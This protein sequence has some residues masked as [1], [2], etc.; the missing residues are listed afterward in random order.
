MQKQFTIRDIARIANVDAS[1]VSRSLNDS[2][3]VAAD[4]KAR[5]RKIA[6]EGN[7]AF[8]AIARSLVT[9]R[10]GIIGLLVP[11]SFGEYQ[12]SLHLT[13]LINEIR[14]RLEVSDLDLITKFRSDAK[15]GNNIRHLV[16]SKR[17]DAL[18]I[19]NPDITPEELTFLH[20]R[21]VPAIFVHAIPN[22]ITL[23]QEEYIFADH[24]AGGAIG[25]NHLLRLGHRRIA[26]FTVDSPEA[27]FGERTRGYENAFTE[28]GLEAD[29]S[30][31]IVGDGT[32][33]FGFN[34]VRAN[35]ER[36]GKDITAI[37]SQTDIAALGAIQA[38]KDCGLSV[39][40]DVAIVAYDDIDFGKHFRPRL[41]TV[42]QPRSRLAV[43]ACNR[44]L[45]ILNGPRD[46]EDS[47]PRLQ[48][49]VMPHLV[50]RESCGGG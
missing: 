25:A 12:Y 39:P 49:R 1:T 10:T 29:N 32:F 20:E 13:L 15:G 41:T 16:E 7:F 42:H 33:E 5:I 21:H 9:H 6:E 34:Y 31:V 35:E 43:A 48:R 4:T 3:L 38:L 28:Y 37:F 46:G 44:L 17:I 50:V 18:I 26:C 47:G 40:N 14:S 36:F 23:E 27:S 11:D 24:E 2:P 19:V 22:R 8:N 30:L 45:E